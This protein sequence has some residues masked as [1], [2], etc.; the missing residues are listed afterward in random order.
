MCHVGRVESAQSRGTE[1]GLPPL[2]KW[3]SHRLTSLSSPIRTRPLSLLRSCAPSPRYNRSRAAS[4]AVSILPVHPVLDCY[5]HTKSCNHW[6][7][8]SH[9]DDSLENCRRG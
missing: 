6:F 7:P 4:D 9:S 2:A 3:P 1:L 8:L 5:R